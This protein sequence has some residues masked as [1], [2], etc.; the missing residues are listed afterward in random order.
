VT[1]SA[2]PLALLVVDDEPKVAAELADA[3][4]DEGY[5]VHVAGSAA[6]ALDLLAREPAIGVMISDI[7]MP[8]MDGIALTRRTLALRGEAEAVEVILVTGHATLEDAIAAIRLGAFDFVRKPFRLSEIFDATSRAMARALGRRRLAALGA[9]EAPSLAGLP[10]HGLMHELRTPLVPI[11]GFAELLEAPRAPAETREFARE[12]REGAGL[13]LTT[14]GDLLALA[15]ME[16]G[17]AAPAALAEIPLAPFLAARVAAVVGFAAQNGVSLAPP[18]AE[19]LPLR[20]EAASL[21]RA[22]EVLLRLAI[23]RAARGA[24]V[25][26]AGQ[27]R[28]AVMALT[29]ATTGPRGA[30]EAPG[31]ADPWQEARQVAPL[32]LRLVEAVAARHGAT[33]ALG[34][35]PEAAFGAV[36]SLPAA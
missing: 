16:A 22:V 1:D 21:S 34:T 35:P 31:E 23:R 3:V 14:V 11:L 32:G 9:R 18:E 26:L 8:G 27:R 24:A 33:L 5:Q 25:R 30:A 17:G 2:H 12:I 28:G 19:P 4:L 29:V 7:R 13:L 15:E 10:L 6:E 20:G 36:L